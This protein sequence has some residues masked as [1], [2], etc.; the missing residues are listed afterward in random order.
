MLRQAR[1]ANETHG[2]VY[3]EVY[4]MRTNIVLDDALV[5]EAKRL[6]GIETKVKLVDTALRELVKN[7][8][9]PS[10]LGLQGKIAFAPG[11]SYKSLR[12]KAR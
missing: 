9:R 6:T 7:R 10:L 11:Y 3:V 8:R 4:D 2:K 1:R 5:E 12:P